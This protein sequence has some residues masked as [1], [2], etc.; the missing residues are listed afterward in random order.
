MGFVSRV[1]NYM[2]AALEILF[3]VIMFV[4][5]NPYIKKVIK[6]TNATSA[7]TFG[8]MFP[9]LWFGLITLG[10]VL[11]VMGIGGKREREKTF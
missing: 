6:K 4:F 9:F 3:G 8:A 2:A 7:K 5:F 10:V 1:K 11:T